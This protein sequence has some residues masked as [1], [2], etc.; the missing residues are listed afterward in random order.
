VTELASISDADHLSL[1]KRNG[2]EGKRILARLAT[3]EKIELAVFLF[4]SERG[5]APVL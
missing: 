5:D 1:I 3:L 4:V 2:Q